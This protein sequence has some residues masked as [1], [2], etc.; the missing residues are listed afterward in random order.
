[1][2]LSGQIQTTAALLSQRKSPSYLLN[3]RMEGLQ[4]RLGR[5]R[6]KYT[7]I[8]WNRTR[9]L[10]HPSRNLDTVSYAYTDVCVCVCMYIYIYIYIYIYTQNTHTHTHTHIYIYIYIYI[11]IHITYVTVGKART[12][13]N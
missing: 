10:G 13:F 8:T 1:M 9:C 6:E 5:V 12:E 7:S 3:S 2:D 11:Y 4:S